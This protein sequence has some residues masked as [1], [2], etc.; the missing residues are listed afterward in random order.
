MP[1]LPEVETTRRV[2]ARTLTGVRIARLWVRNYQLRWP[3]PRTLPRRVQDATVR[4]VRRRAKYLIVD[5]ET[6]GLLVHLGMSGSLTLSDRAPDRHDHIIIETS[7][8][9]RWVYSDPRRFGSFDW[10]GSDGRHPRLDSLGPE[11]WDP[12]FSS[13]YLYTLTRGRQRSLR[14]LLLD[15]RVVAGVGNIYASE[16]A[17]VAGIH[18]LRAVGRISQERYGRLVEATREVLTRA[19][20]AGGTTL[21]DFRFGDS[22]S[23]EYQ[24][25]LC[26][27]DREGQACW[28]CQRVI[29]RR[30]ET[31]RSLY[32]CPGCQR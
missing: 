29:R 20:E 6:G 25:A 3:V 5:F 1:E 11:P 10:I 28:R 24:R 32:Y 2:L 15:S 27:Y 7:C 14:N 8:G 12:A 17:F 4:T 9:V 31:Q 19:I 30:V 21:R 16:I 22:E 13:D 26:V 23:G 18:P